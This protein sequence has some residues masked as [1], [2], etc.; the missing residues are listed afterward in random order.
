[1][2]DLEG[3]VDAIVAGDR[4]RA[5]ASL[6]ANPVLARA[7]ADGDVFHGAI[8]HHV[9]G[10]DTALH[11]AAAA[12]DVVV[13]R[14]LLDAGA[15]VRAKNRRGAEPLHYG[16][17]GRPGQGDPDAQRAM[18]EL[19]VDAGAD[20]NAL[21]KSGVAPIHRAVRTRAI[22]AVNG[23]LSRG[24]DPRKPNKGGSTPL[25]LATSTTGKSGSGSDAARAAQAQIVAVLEGAVAR[26][27]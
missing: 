23:L 24:A 25:A 3:L 11:V 9:Y 10:G 13:A 14:A 8:A 12:C 21:D 15:D 5:L 18:I 27:P 16:S 22:G 4:S 19:L 20:A 7:V 2:N 26:R 1:M 6:A 17:D